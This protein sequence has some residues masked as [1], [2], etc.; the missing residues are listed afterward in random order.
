VE[1]MIGVN[2]AALTA[3]V[4]FVSVKSWDRGEEQSCRQ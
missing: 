1:F 4:M 3:L 2:D